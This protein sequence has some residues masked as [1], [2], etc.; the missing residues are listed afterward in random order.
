VEIL[1]PFYET[2]V[3]RGYNPTNP[4]WLIDWAAARFIPDPPKRKSRTRGRKKRQ[5][6]LSPVDRMLTKLEDNN[7]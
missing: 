3:Q 4:G 6:A 5:E 1:R 7:G 2:W